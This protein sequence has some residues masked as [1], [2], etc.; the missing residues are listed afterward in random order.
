M[1]YLIDKD[2]LAVKATVSGKPDSADLES[3]NLEAVNNNLNLP[4]LEVKAE[5]VDGSITVTKNEEVS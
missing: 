3:R 2:T 1:I 5:R 4:P